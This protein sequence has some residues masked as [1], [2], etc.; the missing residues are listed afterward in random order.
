[1]KSTVGISFASPLPHLFLLRF[2]HSLSI[3][4]RPSFR[5]RILPLPLPRLQFPRFCSLYR[6]CPEYPFSSI[7][8]P[9]FPP[10]PLSTYFLPSVSEPPSCRL[11]LLVSRCLFPIL[12]RLSGSQAIA[13]PVSVFPHCSSAVSS[14]IFTLVMFSLNTPPLPKL[15]SFS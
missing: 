4:S 8:A 3:E 7:L 11:P 14:L 9:F 2:F 5:R 13:S 15:S 12:P 10:L 6:S 1:M